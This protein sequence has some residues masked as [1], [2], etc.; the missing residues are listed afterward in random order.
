MNSTPA[1]VVTLH[2]GKGKV[3]SV[4]WAGHVACTGRQT[5]TKFWLENLKGIDHSKDL[6]ID[7][8]KTLVRID[9]IEIG[10]EDVVVDWIHVA[11]DRDEKNSLH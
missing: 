8:R 5:C 7:G 6:G 3:V 1:Y 2:E 10:W 4:K 9:L 11:Q